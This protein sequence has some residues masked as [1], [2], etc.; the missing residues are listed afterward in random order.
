MSLLLAAPCLIVLS[1]EAGQPLLNSEESAVGGATG[2]VEPRDGQPEEPKDG[3]Q[4]PGGEIEDIRKSEV[5]R[6]MASVRGLPSMR[7][8]QGVD[9]EPIKN[10]LEYEPR[11]LYDIDCSWQIVCREALLALAGVVPLVGV[12]SVS[13]FIIRYYCQNLHLIAGPR[14][15]GRLKEH[16]PKFAIGYGLILVGWN[17]LAMARSYSNYYNVLQDGG[18]NETIK[19]LHCILDILQFRSVQNVCSI[20]SVI[21][22]LVLSINSIQVQADVAFYKFK[23]TKRLSK[24]AKAKLDKLK[25]EFKTHYDDGVRSAPAN[26][27]D[28]YKKQ[29]RNQHSFQKLA[30]ISAVLMVIGLFGMWFSL[31]QNEVWKNSVVRNEDVTLGTI[32]IDLGYVISL[33]LMM[34]SIPVTGM[35]WRK[36]ISYL[37]SSARMIDQNSQQLLLFRALVVKPDVRRW[38]AANRAALRDLLQKF[39]SK[40]WQ[41]HPPDQWGN[42]KARKGLTSKEDLTNCRLETLV[43]IFHQEIGFFDLANREDVEDWWLLRRYTQTDFM[44]ESIFMDYCCAITATLLLGFLALGLM[45][46]TAHK[47]QLI[48]ISEVLAAQSNFDPN[49]LTPLAGTFVIGI[50]TA[51]L[52]KTFFLNIQACVDINGLLSHDAIILLTAAAEVQMKKGNT[53][54]EDSST[55]EEGFTHETYCSSK[56]GSQT[57]GEGTSGPCE[58]GDTSEIL[59]TLALSLGEIDDRQTLFGIPITA[60]LRNGLFLTLTSAFAHY[61][62]KELSPLVADM[63]NFKFIAKVVASH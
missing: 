45:E 42:I 22:L 55:D 37:L 20:G 15:A 10:S 32:K 56:T 41:D 49:R 3:N 43:H 29:Y 2:R 16:F 59:R 17:S 9:Y 52:L 13:Y 44:D 34:I 24:G 5:L 8:I 51:T 46:F 19:R 40:K 57:D 4:K 12:A 11:S 31:L 61:A 47:Q 63:N 30:P 25:N 35:A 60:N 27:H 1:M 23:N 28:L 14:E 58:E 48:E 33:L 62:W 50:C 26:L 54:G 38:S 53:R 39:A 7:T 18:K 6:H 21:L 36:L